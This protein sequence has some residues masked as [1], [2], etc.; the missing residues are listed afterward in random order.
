MLAAAARAGRR[1]RAADLPADEV[2][3]GGRGDLLSRV[4][5]DVAELAEAVVEALPA[6]A[7]R[8]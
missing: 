6:I 5:D 8:R 1:P 3:R 4:G 2:E 7:A